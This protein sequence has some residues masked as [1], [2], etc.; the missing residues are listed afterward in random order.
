MPESD[1][2]DLLDQVD[3]FDPIYD[4]GR[5]FEEYE[6]GLILGRRLQLD[7]D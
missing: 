2:F 5:V 6:I 1:N 3:D 4:D 7:L